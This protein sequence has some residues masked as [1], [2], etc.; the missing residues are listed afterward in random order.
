MPIRIL[1]QTL[2]QRLRKR[3]KPFVQLKAAEV[4]DVFLVFEKLIVDGRVPIASLDVKRCANQSRLRRKQFL[5]RKARSV[6]VSRE[7]SSPVETTLARHVWREAMGLKTDHT[8][9]SSDTGSN[10][11]ACDDEFLLV[12]DRFEC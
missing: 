3:V 2:R 10:R 1:I 12:C 9:N 6:V 11:S 5:N 4:E 7:C 8:R